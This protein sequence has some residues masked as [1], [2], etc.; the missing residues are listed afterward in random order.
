MPFYHPR[1]PGIGT[2]GKTPQMNWTK[3]VGYLKQFAEER[4][5][6]AETYSPP[7][8]KGQDHNRL[9]ADVALMLARAISAGCK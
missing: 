9:M 2:E 3:V 7:N 1:G 5:H 8:S 4:T 6:A